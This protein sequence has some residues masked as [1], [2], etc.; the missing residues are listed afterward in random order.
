MINQE[1]GSILSKNIQNSILEVHGI[2]IF[3]KTLKIIIE[4]WVLKNVIEKLT[5]R[6]FLLIRDVELFI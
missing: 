4:L 2:T 5:L 6:T 1:I 3:A